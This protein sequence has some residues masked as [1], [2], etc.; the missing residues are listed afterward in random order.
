MAPVLKPEVKKLL[1]EGTVIPA[2]PLALDRE[3]KIDGY[4]Q[5]R[6]TRYYLAS[7]AGGLAVGVHTTQFDIRKPEFNYLERVLALASETVALS[8]PTKN[9]IKI[10]GICGTT[11]QAMREAELAVNYGYDLGLVSLAG[12]HQWKDEELIRHLTL[13]SEVIP[14]F[15]FYLQ[16]AVGGR[17]LSFEFWRDFVEI[18]NVHAIKVAAFNRY[19][20]LDVVRAVCHSSR[21]DEIALYTGNDDNII[22]DLLTPYRFSVRGQVIEKRFVGGLLGHWAVWT[23]KAVDLFNETRQ[24]IANN[25][26]GVNELLSKGIIV[27]DMNAAIFDAKNSFKGC[28]SGIHE[29]LRRQGHLEG[30]W[31]LNPE[32]KL[33]AGQLEEIDRICREHEAFTDDEFVKEFLAGTQKD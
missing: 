16:P 19:Q 32:E 1:L 25:Y 26:T 22:A 21:K 15:G 31:C 5:N 20:T 17:V 27:T 8:Q 30:T 7:G 14:V 24:C 4:R 18:P 13:I 33:S 6:L 3:L 11:S 10:A 2:H 12:L 29:V 23:K 28:I 9:F